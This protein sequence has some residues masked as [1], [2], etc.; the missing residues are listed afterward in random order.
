MA[1]SQF[2]SRGEDDEQADKSCTTTH[3]TA[4]KTGNREKFV[5]IMNDSR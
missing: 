2:W 4:T 5:V 1:L 3:P